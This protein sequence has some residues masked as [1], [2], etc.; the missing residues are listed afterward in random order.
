MI[1]LKKHLIRLV[2]GLSL[3]PLM[4]GCSTTNITELVKSLSKDPATVSVSVQS[5]YGTMKFV[6]T[7]P[8]SNQVVTVGSDGTVTVKNP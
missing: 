2:L 4:P 1:H 7:A 5:V 3:I 6:R 8:L